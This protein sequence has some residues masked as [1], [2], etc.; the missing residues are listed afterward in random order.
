[1]EFDKAALMVIESE[2]GDFVGAA[3]DFHSGPLGVLT[4][5][6]MAEGH[7]A[8]I[9]RESSRAKFQGARH[10]SGM[11]S[12]RRP[13]VVYTALFRIAGSFQFSG[14]RFQGGVTGE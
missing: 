2:A 6:V 9:R 14:G 13:V 3:P 11:G 4:D 5:G 12:K 8:I 1:M 10:Q 7:E